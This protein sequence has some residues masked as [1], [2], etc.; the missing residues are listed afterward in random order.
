MYEARK[1]ANY[2]LWRFDAQ[3]FSISNMKMNKLLYFVQGWGYVIEDKALI[4]NHFVAWEYGP[5]IKSIYDEFK[6][7]VASPIAQPAKFMNYKSG[8]VEIVPFDDLDETCINVIEKIA[9]FY[10]EK[11]AAE[12]STITHKPGG[13]W[14]TVR[15]STGNEAAL[16]QRIP[17]ALISE[18]FRSEFGQKNKH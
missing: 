12:L 16:L 8:V 2:L 6:H 1:I 11:T 4:R 15:K 18:C 10:V 17:N 9:P 13:P 5:V 3:E 14:E 7:Y